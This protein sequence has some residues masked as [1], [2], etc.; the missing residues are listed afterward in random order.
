[1]ANLSVKEHTVSVSEAAIM[2]RFMTDAGD[3]VMIWGPPGVGKSDIVR[4]LGLATNR[5]VIEFRTNIREPVDVRGI[6]VP[7]M[8]TG[9]TRWFVPDELPQVERDGEFGILFI[10]EINTG[11][12]QMMAVM[13]QL[14]LDRC[15]GD[16]HLPKGWVIVAAGNRVGDR[17]S[18]QRM[19][20]ALRNRFAHIFV[21]A[22][23][24]S[25]TNWATA[26]DVPPE[27][28]AFIRLRGQDVLHVMP[29]GDENAFPTP[30][31]WTRCGKYVTAPKQHR[32]RLF[33]AHVGDAYAAELDG[34]IDLYNSIGS[35][36]DILTNPADAKVPTEPSVRFAICTA[37]GRMATK[38]TF[39]AIVE[40]AQRLPRESQI[41]V[42]HDATLRDAKL[43]NTATYGQWA[44]ANQDLVIQ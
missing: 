41:L 6:P 22:D 18:A 38:K 15:V 12:P 3:P 8:V 4:Q 27:L 43:K 19:P 34:F 13:F 14:I 26:N 28:V 44:V 20:T 29:K 10:D 9:K 35:L 7:D 39:P 23:V 40:Y 24:A 33:A 11:S 32:M 1:M 2:L 36:D 21:E 37:L 16:Y 30:R 25:W 31:S 17:A 5:K 42:V